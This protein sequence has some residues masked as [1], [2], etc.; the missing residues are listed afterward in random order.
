MLPNFL[1]VG[2][3]RCGTTSICQYLGEHP[4]I[5]MSPKRETEFFASKHI[6][7]PYNGPGDKAII[8]DSIEHYSDLFCLVKDEIAIGECS[9]IYL[10]Y[11]DKVI[12]EI[13]Q[14]LGDPRIVVLLRNPVS[15]AISAYKRMARDRR[16][17][18]SIEYALTRE[19]ERINNNFSLIWHYQKAGLY[20]DS[21]RAYIDAF[22]RV[23]VIMY[24]DL[25]QNP[26]K[27][28]SDLYCFLEVDTNFVPKTDRVYNISGFPR[29]RIFHD[30]IRHPHKIKNF[31]KP[32]LRIFF[33]N[34]KLYRIRQKLMQKGLKLDLPIDPK[35]VKSLRNFYCQDIIKL[36]NMLGRDL[37][38]WIN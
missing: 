8:I 2:A 3:G 35:I 32:F 1:I 22:K 11:A 23:K 15:R 26:Q 12:P 13:K 37:S 30:F 27:V 16:E 28:M 10:Y 34:Q 29:F 36:Q 19:K 4:E 9:P 31:I 17:E 24:D 21:V 5:Y 33:S 7:Q 14:S 20:A 18:Y 6:K 38:S 25:C